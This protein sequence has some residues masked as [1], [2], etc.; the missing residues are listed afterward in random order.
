MILAVVLMLIGL[1]AMFVNA[2]FMQVLYS[3]LA[4]LLYGVFLVYD[5]QLVVGRFSSHYSF[6]DYYLASLALFMDIIQL[7]LNIVNIM[8]A[9]S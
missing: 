5:T 2:P 9:T 6:D 3:G 1:V 8:K 7:F 4:V